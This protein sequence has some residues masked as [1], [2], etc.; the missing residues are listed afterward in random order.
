MT[1]RM[2]LRMKISPPVRLTCRPSLL[3]ERAP[4]TSSGSSCAPLAFDVQQVADVAELA[5]QVAPHRRLVDE[6]GGQAIGAPVFLSRRK[7]LMRCSV[8]GTPDARRDRPGDREGASA[9]A[10]RSTQ[11][12]GQRHRQTLTCTP[13]RAVTGARLSS[14]EDKIADI[15][16]D[17]LA[18]GHAQDR[19]QLPHLDDGAGTRQQPVNGSYRCCGGMAPPLHDPGRYSSLRI[20]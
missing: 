13:N 14:F 17:M 1:P 2:S 4:S 11:L 15:R 12:A 19:P 20:R 3:R 5:V 8:A 6:A 7:R 18:K 9:V 16:A 10:E